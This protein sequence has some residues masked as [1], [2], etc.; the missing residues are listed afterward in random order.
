MKAQLK[1]EK[2]R[3]RKMKK[4]KKDKELATNRQKEAPRLAWRSGAL[5]RSTDKRETRDW[6]DRDRLQKRGTILDWRNGK[7]GRKETGD[8]GYVI[9]YVPPA[10]SP[11]IC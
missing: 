6:T 10:P 11:G 9:R 3:S 5:W 7:R 8:H 2:T 4:K 1:Q